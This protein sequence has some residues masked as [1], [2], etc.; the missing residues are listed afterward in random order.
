MKVNS[1]IETMLNGSTRLFARI[2]LGAWLVAM[3]FVSSSFA[4]TNA[5]SGTQSGAASV[6]QSSPDPASAVIFTYHRV[7]E[8]LYPDNSIRTEQFAE[9]IQE[10][11][12]GHYNIVPLQTITDALNAGKRLP[13]RTVAITFNGAYK[14]AYEHAMPILL[15]RNIPFTVF[16]P[17]AQIDAK[18]P[19]YMSWDDVK[20]L[21]RNNGVSFGLHPASYTRLSGLDDAEIRRQINNTVVRYRAVFKRDPQFFA[22]PFGEYTKEYRDIVASSGFT[23]AFG[24]QSG[25]AYSGHDMFALPRF[26]MTENYGG[27]DRFRMAATALPFPVQEVTPDDPY[28]TGHT[29]PSI[30]FTLPPETKIR[31]NEISCFIS[32]EAMPEMKV[33]GTDKNRIELRVDDAFSEDR[34]RINCTAPGPNPTAGEERRWRWFGLLL[35]VATPS[36]SAAMITQGDTPPAP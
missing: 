31:A 32:G 25:V 5:Q 22:Y 27:L 19:V 34:V 18:M 13:D 3:A 28:V 7:N 21:R 17:T 36:T 26:P 10:L 30:G 33:V 14:S 12:D 15:K 16:L 11:I 35:T 29:S 8:D 23:A 2:L 6:K 9:H 4:Q 20:K 1:I 24:Q